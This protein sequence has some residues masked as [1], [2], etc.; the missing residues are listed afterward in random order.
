N[1]AA[2]SADSTA[3]FKYDAV[4][5]D[6]GQ[7]VNFGCNFLFHIFTGVRWADLEQQQNTTFSRTDL[8][9]TTIVEHTDSHYNDES[10][11]KGVGPQLGIDGRY[12]F[13]YGFGIDAGLTTSLLVG[14]TDNTLDYVERD[15]VPTRAVP[16]LTYSDHF[17]TNRKD[18]VVPA[19]DGNLG[20]D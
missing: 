5:L 14:H 7:K 16:T 8:E 1:T 11:F 20:V 18:R 12:C 2:D 15:T 17:S 6:I 19:V 4:D 10:E 13:G 3:K 9:G